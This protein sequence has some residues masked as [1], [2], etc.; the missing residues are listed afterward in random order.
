MNYETFTDDSLLMMHHGARGALAVDDQLHELGE[1]KRFK[2]R[3][4]ADWLEHVSALEAEMVRRGLRFE[5][6]NWSGAIADTCE[7]PLQPDNAGALSKEESDAVETVDRVARL[8]R[9]IASA[10]RMRTDV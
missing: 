2:V 8:R 1:P 7:V 9:R 5:A 10:L 6:I 4:T 3:E